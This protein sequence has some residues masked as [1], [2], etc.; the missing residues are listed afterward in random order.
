[1]A[2]VQ[3]KKSC[4]CA[5]VSLGRAEAIVLGQTK[6]KSVSYEQEQQLSLF[7]LNSFYFI[8]QLPLI[9]LF[10]ILKALKN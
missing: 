7:F 2:K 6:W 3:E 9:T 8:K 4:T 10:T 1:M 5:C